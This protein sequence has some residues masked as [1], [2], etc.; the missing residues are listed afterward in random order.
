[1]GP[2]RI[3]DTTPVQIVML[4]IALAAQFIGPTGLLPVA[5]PQNKAVA[6][7]IIAPIATLPGSLMF[8]R[9]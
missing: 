3:P 6:V 9:F 1:M 2:L 7:P 8:D 5:Y 4:I